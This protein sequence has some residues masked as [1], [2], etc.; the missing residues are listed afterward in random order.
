MEQNLVDSSK[1]KISLLS[2]DSRYADQRGCDNSSFKIVLPHPMKNIMRVR[3]ASIEIPLV[4]YLFSEQYGNITMAV[5]MGAS[6][7]FIKMKPIEPG[8]YNSQELCDAI[9]TNLKLIHPAFTCTFSSITGRTEI[10]NTSLPF[11]AYLMSYNKNIASRKSY[12]G[13]GYYLGFRTGRISSNTDADDGSYSIKSAS[14][15]NIQQ[16]QY[17][18]LQLKAPDDIVNVQHVLDD[19]GFLNAFAKI[20]LKDG[21]F[22]IAFDDNSNLLRKEYTFLAPVTI[23]FFNVILLNPF[24]E[25]V[26]ML[27]VDWSITLEIT[28]IV[29][30]KTY[31][32]LSNTYQR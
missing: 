3:L 13:I 21:Y 25:E 14:V 18:L 10:K 32:K 27:N 19:D 6:P 24:G 1:Y 15:L 9:T 8:N 29:N 11:E 23:P 26:N 17:Y 30:S 28:E 20:V 7:T 22:T 12:W 2:L 4:E 16:N 31:T 5:R